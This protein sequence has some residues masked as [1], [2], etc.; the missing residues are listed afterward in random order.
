LGIP[1]LAKLFVLYVS[2]KKGNF[3]GSPDPKLGTKPYPV[4]YFSKKL[5]VTTLGGPRCL[6]MIATTALLVK[7]AI[8]ITLGQCLE[9][10]TPP[11]SQRHTGIKKSLVDVWG[12]VK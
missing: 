12:K 5:D 6:R 7:E 8:K 11:S 1:N 2:N 4:A 9:V 10:L 3:Y